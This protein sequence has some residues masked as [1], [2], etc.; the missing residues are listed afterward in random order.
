VTLERVA[1]VIGLICCVAYFTK[2]L[3]L[4]DLPGIPTDY[5]AVGFLAFVV[6]SM[7]RRTE[8]SVDAAGN[9]G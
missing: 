1:A 5:M 6:V 8:G 3:G 2:R 4:V 9:D 7:T